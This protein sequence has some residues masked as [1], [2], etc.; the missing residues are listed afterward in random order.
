MNKSR[1]PHAVQAAIEEAGEWRDPVFGPTIVEHLSRGIQ[2][3]IRSYLF[4]MPGLLQLRHFVL[5]HMFT[6]ESSFRVGSHFFFKRPHSI[7]APGLYFGEGSHLSHNVEI[8]YTGGVSIGRDVWISQNVLIET[9]EHAVSA[10]PKQCWKKRVSSLTIGDDAWI[11]AN[12]VVLPGVRYIGRGAIIGA[13]AVL[14]KDVPDFT[15]M[16]GIPAKEIKK[17]GPYEPQSSGSSE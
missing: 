14:T 15:I 7:E 1:P 13:G 4:D 2:L 16:A 3:I 17:R 9:H 12:V 5:R 8:D 11:G 10:G 6:A